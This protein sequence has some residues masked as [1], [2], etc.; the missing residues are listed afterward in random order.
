MEKF[1]GVLF[2]KE[3]SFVPFQEEADCVQSAIEKAIAKFPAFKSVFCWSEKIG[4][5]KI[6]YR[7]NASIRI[8]DMPELEHRIS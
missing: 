8:Y 4:P 6:E 7:I 1:R 3:R 5:E 2:H